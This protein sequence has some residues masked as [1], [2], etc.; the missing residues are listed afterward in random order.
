[1]LS[2]TFMFET[3]KW[4]ICFFL[5]FFYAKAEICTDVSTKQCFFKNKTSLNGTRVSIFHKLTTRV[6]DYGNRYMR[7]QSF[8]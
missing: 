5:F 1:M 4:G 2:H 7:F 8:P 3:Q 6:L